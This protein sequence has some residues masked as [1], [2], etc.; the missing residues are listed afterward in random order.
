MST[1]QVLV[2]VGTPIGDVAELTPRAL[3]VLRDAHMIVCEDT[4]KLRWLLREVGVA[5]PERVVVA[6]DHTEDAVAAEVVAAVAE[7]KAVAMVSDAGMPGIADPGS[8]MARAVLDAGF[9]VRAVNGPSAAIAALVVSGL[10]SGRFVFEGFVPRSGGDRSGRIAEVVA[11]RRTTVLYESPRR[12]ARLLAELR[13]GATADRRVAVCRELTKTHEEVWRGTVGEAEAWLAGP[14]EAPRGDPRGE[15]VVVLEGVIAPPADDD[16]IAAALA[17]H[18]ADG[19]SRRDAV[20]LVAIEMAVP[21]NRVY[22]IA[23][24][25]P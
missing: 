13:E 5:M 12:I 23:T 17:R 18:H 2:L 24:T 25:T 6:N 4:R 1:D 19:R 10:P 9:E 8:R 11:E 14:P 22:A 15:F 7:G 3:A 20:D 16:A 21:R